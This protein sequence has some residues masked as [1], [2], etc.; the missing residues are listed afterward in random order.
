MF[1]SRVAVTVGLWAVTVAG[2]TVGMVDAIPPLPDIADAIT[3]LSIN[4]AAVCSLILAVRRCA[5]PAIET[6][7]AG[8]ARG[9]REA[10]REAASPE[11]VPIESRLR[12]VGR[13]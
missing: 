5:A 1:Y 2:W 9:R 10:F 8:V 3:T 4:A 11:V 12:V 7:L 13:G 6:Y